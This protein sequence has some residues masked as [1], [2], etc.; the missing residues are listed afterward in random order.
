LQATLIDLVCQFGACCVHSRQD[1]RP[2][3]AGQFGEVGHRAHLHASA[4]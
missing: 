1:A 4:D 3:I 2:L